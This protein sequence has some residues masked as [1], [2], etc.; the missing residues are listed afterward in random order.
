MVTESDDP[1]APQACLASEVTEPECALK[2]IEY[3][4]RAADFA[5][6]SSSLVEALR[7]E[8]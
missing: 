1:C 2:A 7:Y 5:Y 6:D 3:W 4:S 8:P